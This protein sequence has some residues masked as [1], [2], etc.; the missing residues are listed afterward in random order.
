L[1]LWK[2]IAIAAVGASSA[3]AT[4]RAGAEEA[5]AIAPAAGNDVWLLSSRYAAAGGQVR[6]QAWHYRAGEWLPSSSDEFVAAAHHE[7]LPTCF[8]IHGNWVDHYT[9]AAEGWRVYE[10]LKRYAPSECRFRFVIWSWPATQSQG[11]LRDVRAKAVCS[12]LHAYYLARLLRQLPS[13]AQVSVWGFSYG[14]RLGAGALHL[15]GGGSLAGRTLTAAESPGSPPWADAASSPHPRRLRGVL[16]AP[17]AE[18]CSLA[19]GQRHGQ[20]LQV[21]EQLLV[22]YNSRDSVLHWYPLLYGLRGPTALGHTGV[23][24]YLAE[25]RGKVSQIDAAAWIGNQHD[26]QP[27]LDSPALMGRAAPLLLFQP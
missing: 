26:W 10:A 25:N 17:G 1:V 12:D 14:A 16:L 21:V 13:S 2:A 6:L 7:D 19:A 20:A 11:A 24:G 3:L 8:W 23:A 5:A 15:L 9:A 4:I 18:S 22:L 27:Y